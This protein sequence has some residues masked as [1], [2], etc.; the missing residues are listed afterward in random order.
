MHVD[1]QGSGESVVL[2]HGTPSS[3]EDFVPLAEALARH[4]RVLVP[5]LPGYGRT[6]AIP[7]GTGLAQR[8]AALVSALKE[9]DVHRAHVVGFSGGA[10]R[11]LSL[12]VAG[13]W[14]A[15]SLFVFS[16]LAAL[17]PA[18][19]SGFEQFAA[20]ID[21]GADLTPIAASRFLS[22]RFA[23][24]PA[25]VEQVQRWLTETDR[26]SLAQELREFAREFVDVTPRLGAL[27]IP[28][29]ARHGSAD[30]AVPLA[31][32]ETLVAATPGAVLERVDGAGH[33]LLIE[34]A[35]ATVAA[36]LAHLGRA[37]S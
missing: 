23:A 27:R 15:R 2:L 4:Y 20:A 21:A 25:A 10:L 3:P 11:A 5:H 19:R 35:D 7:A 26:A 18:E 34:D 17:S 29:T 36:I 37:A 24:D 30:V 6:P 22:P 13:Q 28:V 1:E 14:Q 16:G 8:H 9:R 33:A 32:A 31:H 12:T